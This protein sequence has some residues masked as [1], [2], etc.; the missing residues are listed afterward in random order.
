MKSALVFVLTLRR[1]GPVGRVVVQYH[2]YVF[3]GVLTHR[4]VDKPAYMRRLHAF[5][6]RVYGVVGLECLE[7]LCSSYDVHP[8]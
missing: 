4:L 5:P 3:A 8:L 2:L 7:Y 6:E 1:Y